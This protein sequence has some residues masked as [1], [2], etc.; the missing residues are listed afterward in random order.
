MTYDLPT[1]MEIGGTE[2]EIR[3][4]YRAVIDIMAALSDPDL[5]DQERAQAVLSI[6]YF[7]PDWTQIPPEYMREAIE[8]ILWFINCGEQKSG[9]KKPPLMSWEQDFPYIAAPVNKIIGTDIRGIQYD[10]KTNKGGLHFWTFIS[11]Y[12]EIG[13][14]LFAQIVNIRSKKAK[15][16]KLDKSEQQFYRENRHLVDMKTTYT[17]AEQDLLKEWT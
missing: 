2:Y 13:D 3:T 9:K 12:Y 16:K 5:T 8:K 1:S 17:T 4:D 11:A 7:S 10:P 15:G 6:F 14:C